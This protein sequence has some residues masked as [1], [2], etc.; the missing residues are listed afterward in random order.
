MRA[1]WWAGAL[2]PPPVPSSSE[3]GA[4]RMYRS[5]LGALACLLLSLGAFTALPLVGRLAWGDP[6]VPQRVAVAAALGVVA[7]ALLRGERL[8]QLVLLVATFVLATPSLGT[9]PVANDSTV[10]MLLSAIGVMAARLF[11]MTRALALVAA[12]GASHAATLAVLDLPET[13]FSLDAMVLVVGTAAAAIGFVNAMQASAIAT[14]RVAAS[15]RERERDLARAEAELLARTTSRRVLHDDVLGTLHLVSDS[16]APPERIRQQCR[17]TAEAIRR[18]IAAAPDPGDDPHHH[19]ADDV[20]DG[21]VTVPDGAEQPVPEAYAELVEA[22]RA[23]APVPIDLDVTGRPQRLPAL[24]EHHRSVLVRAA[25]EGV[26]NAVRHGRVD[27]VTLR[28]SADRNEVRVEVLDRGAGPGAAPRK[29]FG[30]RESVERPLAQVG[31]RSALMARP[32]GGAALVLAIP[33]DQ[34]GALHQ[35]YGLTTSGLG[36]VRTL[37]RTV[38]LPLGAAWCVIAAHNVVAH[39]STWPLLVVGLAWVALTAL[40]VRRIE[41]GGPAPLWVAGVSLATVAVQVTGLALLPPGAMLDFRSWTIGMSAVPLVV[42]VL[43]LPLPVGLVVVMAHVVLV[44]LAPQLRPELSDGL[45]PWGSLNGVVTCPVPS[46]V[47]GTLIRRQG[48]ALRRQ[49][50]RER[51]LD[52]RRATE[53]WRATMTDLYFAHVKDEVLPWLDAIADGRRAPDSPETVAQARLLAVAARD[54]LYAPGFFDDD[55]RDDVARFRSAGGVVELRAGLHPGGHE[56]AV[57][58][59]LRALLPASPGRRIIV[60]PPAADDRRVR[61]SV[62]PAP[63]PSALAAVHDG[64]GPVVAADVDHYRAV[65]LVDDLPGSG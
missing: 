47:L 31:G 59:V 50:G 32:G 44:A 60:T 64:A 22:L 62:V 24:G 43:S 30:L 19:A 49:R 34:E 56:R 63:D 29:G 8:W 4:F 25:A 6:T 33:R 20:D 23:Q 7:A 15:N 2:A 28:L 35:A 36:P 1:P 51:A 45:F 52:Q 48:R 3:G 9:F 54:D 26:R 17:A 27:R 11:A 16:V 14:D 53:T 58:R 57:G 39:P 21:P 12:L 65:L 38:A 18:V 41:R 40:V 37:S 10:G 42:L 55:L 61:I 46:L 5:I 13:G